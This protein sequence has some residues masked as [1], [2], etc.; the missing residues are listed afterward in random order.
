M[1]V[2][3]VDGGGPQARAIFF[4][5]LVPTSAHA[6]TAWVMGYDLYPVTTMEQKK[7]WLPRAA[8]EG[9]LCIFEHDP[10]TPVGH[11]VEERAAR[12][13]AAALAAPVP[14]RP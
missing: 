12:F 8:A 3:T 5:D 6:P 11:L 10:E 2:V 14:A 7:Y 9:W 1:C 4:A 13:R